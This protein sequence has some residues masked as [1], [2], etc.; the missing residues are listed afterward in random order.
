MKCIAIAPLAEN[1]SDEEIKSL[2][3]YSED[4][5]GGSQV[6]NQ[7]EYIVNDLHQIIYSLNKN[8]ESIDDVEKNF[9]VKTK[10]TSYII[11]IFSLNL[12][13]DDF[14]D[15]GYLTRAIEDF[16]GNLINQVL[17]NAF[18]NSRYSYVWVNRTLFSSSQEVDSILKGWLGRGVQKHSYFDYERTTDEVSLDFYV[19]WGNNIICVNSGE[20]TDDLI[21][22]FCK[23]MIDAQLIWINYT[24]LT[25][26]SREITK[27]MNH[28]AFDTKKYTYLR[29][30]LLAVYKKRALMNTILDEVETQLQGVRYHVATMS[31]DAWELDSVRE[32]LAINLEILESIN[33]QNHNIV[34]SKEQ[35]KVDTLLLVLSILTLTQF[36]LMFVDLSYNGG[37][38]QVPGD[39]PLSMGLMGF[40][41]S[42]SA[43]VWIV[44]SVF[45]T[46]LIT[47]LMMKGRK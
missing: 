3:K 10:N 33:N 7:G 45:I 4:S 19:S 43:D 35:S 42:I 28:G 6:K 15:S 25:G 37:A 46:A 38:S 24:E 29:D 44:F 21:L 5:L 41:R 40:I 14:A 47:Y 22:E 27:K 36:I 12:E 8:K 11:S 23:G 30:Q 20:L 1:V 31:L 26:M 18:P 39:G 17:L 13:A 2:E 34:R 16:C 9:L 32:R